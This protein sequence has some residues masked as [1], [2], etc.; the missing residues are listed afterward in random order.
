M[1]AEPQ[2]FPDEVVKRSLMI[3]TTT[4]L[5]AHDE[6]LRQRLQG[7]IQEMRRGLTGHLYRRYLTEVLDRLDDERLPEDWLA[8]SSSVLSSI[9]SQADDQPAPDWLRSITWL[10]YA[11]K[12]YDRVKARL[13]NLL[14]PTAYARSEGVVTNGWTIDGNRVIVWQS[15]DAFGRSDFSWEDVPSTLD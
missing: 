12:R 3:Y 9:L 10:D 7:R 1:N 14:R 15:R 6:S 13:I 2:S 5:P 4:A 8:L 11:E